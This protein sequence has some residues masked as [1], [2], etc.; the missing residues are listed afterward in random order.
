[1]NVLCLMYGLKSV[2]HC[3]NVD[4]VT[5]WLRSVLRLM[6][7]SLW[8][9]LPVYSPPHPS[10]PPTLPTSQPPTPHHSH[11]QGA[12]VGSASAVVLLGLAG[13]V[14]AC[15]EQ[16]RRRCQKRIHERFALRSRNIRSE[17]SLPSLL[18]P[19]VTRLTFLRS[20]SKAFPFF[21]TCPF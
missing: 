13:M 16:K 6:L 11:A 7:Y 8:L 4:V 15:D 18:V 19:P 2:I 9:L 20:S 21:N 10:H 1:M 12:I 3:H 14:K 17:S 5:Q